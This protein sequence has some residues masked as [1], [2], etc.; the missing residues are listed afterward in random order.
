LAAVG[1][2]HALPARQVLPAALCQAS[3][4]P[5]ADRSASSNHLFAGFVPR[6]GIPSSTLADDRYAGNSPSRRVLRCAGLRDGLRSGALLL[7]QR[8]LLVVVV[9]VELFGRDDDGGSYPVAVLEVQQMYPL[10][11]AAGRTNLFGIDTNDLA[12]LADDHQFGMLVNEQNCCRLA[13]LRGGFQIVDALCAARSQTILVNIG[14]FAETVLCNG[15]NQRSRHT[16]LFVQIFQS[17]PCILDGFF[18]GLFSRFQLLALRFV[19]LLIAHSLQG[20]LLLR[21]VGPQGGELCG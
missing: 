18:T 9:A 17:H 12:E 4:A 5:P 13:H 16:E 3:C 6:G 1:V 19:S 15:Q 11:R 21:I 10:R 14:P 8:A 2:H 7:Q 20:I